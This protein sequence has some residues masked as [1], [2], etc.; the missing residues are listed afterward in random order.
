MLSQNSLNCF[1]IDIQGRQCANFDCLVTLREVIW[2]C[3]LLPLHM[4]QL[5]RGFFQM[6]ELTKRGISGMILIL[7][8]PAV[9][10]T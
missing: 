7:I 10:S 1:T 4:N 2:V 8:E 9:V 3:N 6:K 5:E